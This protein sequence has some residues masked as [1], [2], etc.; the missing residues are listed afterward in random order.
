MERIA[1]AVEAAKAK[2]SVRTEEIRWK[3][4]SILL[5]VARVPL[6][7]TV[8]NP[9]SHRIKPNLEALGADA[10]VVQSDPYGAAAQALIAEILRSTRG[11][12][13][14]K[15]ALERDSQLHPGVLTH[16]GVLVNANTR[17][18]ALEELGVAYIDV[19]V[20]PS[21]ATERE[22]TDLELE[23]QMERDVK[24]DYTFSARMLFIED[25]M[26]KR[27]LKAEE[28]GLRLERDLPDD[29]RGRK[30]AR[31]TVEQEM[32]L[33]R[34]AREVVVASDGAARITDFDDDRQALI[35]IDEDF[36]RERARNEG[37]ARRVRD[38]QLAGLTA[39]VDYRKLRDVDA[40]LIDSYLADALEEQSTLK[41]FLDDLVGH[42]GGGEDPDD[43]G[44]GDIDLVDEPDTP[45]ITGPN[46][47]RL[48]KHLVSAPEDGEM[49]LKGSSGDETSISRQ[50]VVASVN[51]AF[52]T[53]ID[54]KRRDDKAVDRLD[55]PVKFVAEA[56]RALDRAKTAY[57]AVIDDD[58]F[59]LDELKARIL[60]LGRA[61]DDFV[62]SVE[63]DAS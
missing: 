1:E 59:D 56:T 14:I 23:L 47:E 35:E 9:A 42:E 46:V 30:K 29:A 2:D 41:P 7:A 16:K 12:E 34:L 24:Q 63:N 3:D 5:N 10:E 58:L 22:I 38:A 45:E 37:E 52:V 25:L 20:L 36:E 4:E 53:A 27:G 31:E 61:Y 32:R 60:D 39:D 17:R 26:I 55:A 50:A 28:I 6:E 18:V 8:L 40:L 49:T 57:D 43:S 11:F 51:A 44:L 21:D 48:F 62:S 54:A 15:G 33:L 19:V 13:R